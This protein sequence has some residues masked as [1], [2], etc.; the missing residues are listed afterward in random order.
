MTKLSN[1]RALAEQ[2]AETEKP[3]IVYIVGTGRSGST[4]VANLL[5]EAASAFSAGELR[6]LWRRAILDG[7]ICGCQRSVDDCE[8]WSAAFAE[9]GLDVHELAPRIDAD[10]RHTTRVRRLMKR[11]AVS[12][13]TSHA[14][15]A[16]Y[17]AVGTTSGAQVIVDSS[18]LPAYV[19]LLRREVPFNVRMLHVTRDPRATAFSW[20]RGA[21]STGI[22]GLEHN[23]HRISTAKS[24][25]L[26]HLWNGV[27]KA[28]GRRD[29]SSYLHIRYE[30]LID[31]PKATMERMGTFA[32]IPLSELPDLEGGQVQLRPNH[33]IAGNPGRFRTGPT[34]LKNDS[35]W[36]SGLSPLKGTLVTVLTSPLLRRLGYSYR[37]RA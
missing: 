11:Q 7:R 15:E 3:T 23:M 2:E 30:E 1:E 35:E 10:L 27:A 32:G 26:W 20:Q 25:V 21:A 34:K 29:D 13:E 17:T 4:L 36:Q 6:Y 8:F 31:N 33:T 37:W 24:A 28:W 5:G 9:S 16:L 12:P 14:L 19:S 18:K 22:R